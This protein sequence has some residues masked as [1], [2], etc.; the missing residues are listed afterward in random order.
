MNPQ[1][2]EEEIKKRYSEKYGT[3]YL[4]YELANE[5]SFLNLQLLALRDA[6]FEGIEKELLEKVMPGV[7]KPRFLDIGSATG[8]LL[9]CLKDRGWDCTGVEIS[10][11]Q[12]EYARREKKLDIKSLPLHENNFPPSQFDIVHASHLIEHLNDPQSFI[13][14]VSRILKDGGYVFIA[15]PN[16]DGFQSK[17]FGGR[18]R[19]AIFDHLYLFSKRTLKRLLTNN[20]FAIEKVST[21]GGLAAG[22]AP[23]PIKRIFDRAAKRL[24]FG[25]V[26]IVRAR[27]KD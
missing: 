6:G 9:A 21:W 8:S 20:G 2:K 17:L 7:E 5:E 27:R 22:I 26:M 13:K 3:N 16:I 1:P 12:A 18:W 4:E 19:S 25:D 10:E 14:E 11:P 23:L 24:G 15:T